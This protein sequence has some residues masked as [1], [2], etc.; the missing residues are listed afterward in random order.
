MELILCNTN[1]AVTTVVCQIKLQPEKE[2]LILTDQTNIFL[3]FKTLA[4]PNITLIH[5]N[6]SFGLK[7]II[8]LI[9]TKLK[10]KKIINKFGIEGCYMYHQAF[11]DLYNWA[12]HYCHKI[13]LPITYFRQLSEIKH[14]KASFSLETIK[15]YFKYNVLYSCNIEVIDRGNNHLIPKLSKSFIKD[16][17]IQE[18][19]YQINKDVIKNIAN[20]LI[21]K[22]N[23]NISSNKVI[24]LTGSVM[25]TNQVT[26]EEYALKIKELIE[27]IGKDNVIC[28]CHPRFNDETEL[29]KM[30]P[31]IPG[32][33]PMEFLLEYFNV[34]I[35]YNSTILIEAANNKKKAI[36]LI[37]YFKPTNY[38][39]RDRWFSYFGK[40][41]IIYPQQI[42]DIEL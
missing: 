14:P 35:G 13:G 15:L 22:L 1:L 19:Q 31:H 10:I 20:I 7:D 39:R 21:T 37:N 41:K 17:D 16:N 6:S 30:L 33:I 3:F 28:K 24:L 2:F 32:F 9:R 8:S 36:S 12:I 29:E 26:K 4:L 42:K 5:I 38:Q 18:K 25:A 40:S 27:H 23:I 11:G 34:F